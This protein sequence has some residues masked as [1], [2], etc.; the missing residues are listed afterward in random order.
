MVMTNGS[1]IVL[2]GGM[3][4]TLEVAEYY[5]DKQASVQ[6]NEVQ[7]G[8]EFGAFLDDR[9]SGVLLATIRGVSRPESSSDQPQACYGESST[10]APPI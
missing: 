6:E 8:E 3:C 5:A 10:S 2:E 9:L 4:R 1:V 7:P